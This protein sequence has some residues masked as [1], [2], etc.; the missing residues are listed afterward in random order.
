MPT[1]GRPTVTIGADE[2]T[3]ATLDPDLL[4]PPAMAGAQTDI[5]AFRLSGRDYALP[6]TA[7]ELVAPPQAPT[8]VPTVPPHVRGIVHLRGRILTVIDLAVVLELD[9]EAVDERDRRLVVVAADPHPYAFLVDA[10]LGVR[11]V[12][13]VDMHEP[14]ELPDEGALVLGRVDDGH[15]VLTVLDPAALVA[16]MLASGGASS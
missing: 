11:S 9:T 5:F 2:T 15:G 3:T 7:V 13:D 1:A 8:P 16:H 10:T 4:R 14:D 12:D 6:A